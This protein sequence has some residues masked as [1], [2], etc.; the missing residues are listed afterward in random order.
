MNFVTTS[1]VSILDAPTPFVGNPKNGPVCGQIHEVECGK[2]HFFIY[3]DGKVAKRVKNNLLTL[4]GA[5]H[6]VASVCPICGK[7]NG[8]HPL[9]CCYNHA[10]YREHVS[11]LINATRKVVKETE[12]VTT[13]ATPAPVPIE[14]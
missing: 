13:K 11:A 6:V 9:L 8:N 10:D 3:S 4:E 1:T 7:G 12:V 2:A 5:P 14:S